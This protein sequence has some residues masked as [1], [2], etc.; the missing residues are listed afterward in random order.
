M[1]QETDPPDVFPEDMRLRDGAMRDEIVAMV[2]EA[3]NRQGFPDLTL[4]TVRGDPAHREAFIDMLQDCRPLPVVRA[5][6][7]DARAGRL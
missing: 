4:E 3:L 6:I 5:L 1:S 2:I 7:A